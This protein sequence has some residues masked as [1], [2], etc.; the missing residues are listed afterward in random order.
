MPKGYE[1]EGEI[2]PSLLV[3]AV[4]PV[5]CAGHM[6]ACARYQRCRNGRPDLDEMHM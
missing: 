2:L 5:V 3:I 6:G 1:Q 4:I